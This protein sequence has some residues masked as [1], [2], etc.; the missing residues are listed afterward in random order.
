MSAKRFR[1]DV[2]S[3]KQKER[4]N[5]YY[6]FTLLAGYIL[7]NRNNQNI[8]VQPDTPKPIA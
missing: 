1:F 3:Q 2:G 8:Y 6:F 7:R 5:H 4:K